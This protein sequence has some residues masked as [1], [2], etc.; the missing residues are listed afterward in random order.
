MFDISKAQP[1]PQTEQ[2]QPQTPQPTQGFDISKAQPLPQ[3]GNQEAN[4]AP[5]TES[6][7]MSFING[8]N[9]SVN[10]LAIGMMKAIT[11]SGGVIE[12]AL[13]R[14]RNSYIHAANISK[15]INP[16]S[17]LLGHI[18]GGIA[19]SA[20]LAVAAPASILGQIAAYTGGSAVEGALENPDSG[21]SRTSNAI[22][23]GIQGLAGST[24]GG[25]IQGVAHLIPSTQ[26]AKYAAQGSIKP[27]VA[28]ASKN[29]G[30]EVS[31]FEANS[32]PTL[33]KALQDKT[34]MTPDKLEGITKHL[35]A[36]EEKLQS[37]FN[38]VMKSVE[39][40]QGGKTQSDIYKEL[41]PRQIEPQHLGNILPPK[42]VVDEATG[43]ATTPKLNYVQKLYNEA[44]TN[45]RVNWENIT[46]GSFE[47]LH[48]VSK[49][50]SNVIKGDTTAMA[51]AGKQGVSSSVKGAEAQSLREA[52]GKIKDA[53]MTVSSKDELPV[54]NELAKKK[55]FATNISSKIE[56]IAN[57]GEA[58]SSIQILKAV[59]GTK[60]KENYFLK[61]VANRGG[62]VQKAKDFLEVT[63]AIQ[64]SP[65]EKLLKKPMKS[66]D[67]GV[68]TKDVGQAGITAYVL[69]PAV[70]G[71]GFLGGL[72]KRGLTSKGYYKEALKGLEEAPKK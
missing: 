66:S 70:A 34:I 35:Q 54:A 39:P 20:P 11:P 57:Q 68:T 60:A 51:T 4:N 33:K 29:L 65:L 15:S 59:A 27:E 32:S 19:K 1:L 55:G 18:A 72:A 17:T 24:A 69:G 45:S 25:L 26:I 3:S 22:I 36:R 5:P 58:P 43:Q 14:D 64:N 50:I 49:Y 71:A 28:Q 12:H 56:A 31:P 41:N 8:F 37:T 2:A 62:D 23:G 7:G 63:K 40:A 38:D 13:D 21:E 30:I 46:P 52:Q 67:F 10:K 53:M 6:K 42:P 48:E 9:D 44:H 47:D 16:T 61:S